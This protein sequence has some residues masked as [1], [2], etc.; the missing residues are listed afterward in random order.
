MDIHRIYLNITISVGYPIDNV[1]ITVMKMVKGLESQDI[2]EVKMSSDN[3][4]AKDEEDFEDEEITIKND[5]EIANEEEEDLR[6]E[7]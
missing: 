6:E 1:F 5:E 3:D 2:S 4:K 7:Q